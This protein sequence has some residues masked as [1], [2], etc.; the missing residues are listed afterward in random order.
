MGSIWALLLARQVGS[1]REALLSAALL[2]FSYHHIWFSQNARG[3]SGLLFWTNFSS[4]LFLRALREERPQLWLLYA[5]AAALGV[6][7]H[8]NMLFVIMGQ[9]IM[10]LVM[11]LVRRKESWPNRWAGFFLGFCLAS[12]LTF[13]LHALVMPQIL[14]IRSLLLI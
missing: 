4:W 12:F 10:Y 7:T 3:Y 14:S 11:L 8:M 6:Y 5:A 1:I 9:F 2:T 13:Q